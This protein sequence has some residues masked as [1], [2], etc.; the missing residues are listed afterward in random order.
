MKGTTDEQTHQDRGG[1]CYRF[2]R[3][4]PLGTDATPFHLE[5]H[6]EDEDS[7]GV[8]GLSMQLDIVYD[9]WQLY[10]RQGPDQLPYITEAWVG[11]F[12]FTNVANQRYVTI[13]QDVSQND[14]SVVDNGDG[15]LSGLNLSVG[16]DVMRDAS[17]H[18]LARSATNSWARFTFDEAST[19]L[20]RTDDEELAWDVVKEVVRGDEDF[21]PFTVAAVTDG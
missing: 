4:P 2:V 17:G 1:R 19:P 3:H 11:R 8:A 13:R 6:F 21:C 12:R 10:Q 7:C 14:L 9:G 16:T 18:H 15:T 5:V 20:D